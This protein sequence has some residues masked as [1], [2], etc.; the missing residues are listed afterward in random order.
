[1]SYPRSRAVDICGHSSFF[2]SKFKDATRLGGS[3]L[4]F[5][6]ALSIENLPVEA[7]ME[8]ADSWSKSLKRSRRYPL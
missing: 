7:A 3:F 4:P 6:V 2:P 8:R 1:M 5:L